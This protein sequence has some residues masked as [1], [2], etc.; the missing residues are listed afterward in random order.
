MRG[1]AA[2]LAE[3]V[4]LLPPLLTSSVTSGETFATLPL[5]GSEHHLL[6]RDVNNNIAVLI[7]IDRN[8]PLGPLPPVRLENL[9]VSHAA[10]CRI[11]RP[12]DATTEGMFSVVRCLSADPSL[13]GLFLEVMASVA[14]QFPV[15]PTTQ[16]AADVLEQVIRI[17]RELSKP[18]ERTVQGLWAELFILAGA[19]APAVV[20]LAWRNSAFD[21]TDFATEH[22]RLEVKSSS[23]A[24]R[25]HRFG[26][27]QLWLPSGVN[28]IVASLF[29][30]R[31]SGGMS[32]GELWNAVRSRVSADPALL[33][34]V[35]GIV[36]ETLGD[37]WKESLMIR[38]D[39]RTARETLRFYDMNTIPAIG[40]RIP[41]EIS[42][43]HFRVDLSRVGHLSRSV[44]EAAGGLFVAALPILTSEG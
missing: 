22:Q 42:E 26:A 30:Q 18:S 24:T 5:P 38:F 25:S 31:S 29:C 4:K 9:A 7:A 28:G 13:R 15:P 12:S 3:N 36:S 44:L 17:F 33:L 34:R 21:R 19:I 11:S 1:T 43:I 20:A 16:K 27:E 8:A 23:R 10:L 6:G 14:R 2:Q 41:P 40:N 32:V 35:D 37:A 39:W